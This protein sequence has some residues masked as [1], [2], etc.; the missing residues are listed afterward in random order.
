MIK[1]MQNAYGFSRD[2]EGRREKNLKRSISSCPRSQRGYVYVCERGKVSG[3]FLT[4]K[5][6]FLL[7]IFLQGDVR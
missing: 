2:Q 7:L 5:R 1:T 4:H 6:S 3:P